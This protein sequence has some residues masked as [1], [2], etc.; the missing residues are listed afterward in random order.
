M[1][2]AKKLEGKNRS[3]KGGRKRK[4]ENECNVVSCQ[5]GPGFVSSPTWS[6]GTSLDVLYAL[7]HMSGVVL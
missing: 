6:C 5:A 1:T 3:K 4:R 7:S 2:G